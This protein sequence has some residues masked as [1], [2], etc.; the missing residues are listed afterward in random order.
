MLKVTGSKEAK[1]N[2][3]YEIT[4]H[5]DTDVQMYVLISYLSLNKLSEFCLKLLGIGEHTFEIF[6]VEPYI[7]GS[8]V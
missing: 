2:V 1:Q 4:P 3:G 6:S 7:F 8:V 5:Q